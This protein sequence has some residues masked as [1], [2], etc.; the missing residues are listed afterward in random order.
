M[1]QYRDKYITKIANESNRLINNSDAFSPKQKVELLRLTNNY[2]KITSPQDLTKD[3]S[4]PK[5]S[6][7]D[8]GKAT[9]VAQ[10]GHNAY[11]QSSSLM[12]DM[13]KMVMMPENNKNYFGKK[14]FHLD[15]K[16]GCMKSSIDLDWGENTDKVR[17]DQK[18]NR[19]EKTQ[20]WPKKK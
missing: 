4:D 13:P 12:P 1:A 6:L 20:I 19:Q 17:L 3:K 15:Q 18:L 11:L 5:Q 7:I 8:Q 16:R 14:M 10:K 2:L 9:M